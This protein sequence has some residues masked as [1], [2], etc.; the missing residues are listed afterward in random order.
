MKLATHTK[1][2]HL[3]ITPDMWDLLVAHSTTNSVPVSAVVRLILT[4]WFNEARGVT[5]EMPRNRRRKVA[6]G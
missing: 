6:N 4:R 2:L 3:K 5:L 1:Q